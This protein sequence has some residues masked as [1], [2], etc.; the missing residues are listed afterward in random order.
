MLRRLTSLREPQ[1]MKRC[2]SRYSQTSRL[3]TKAVG[4]KK[5]EFWDLKYV[6][7]I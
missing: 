4:K 6:S 3:K 5:K 7:R 1:S 2:S